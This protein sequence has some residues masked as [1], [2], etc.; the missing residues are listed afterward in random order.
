MKNIHDFVM[1]YYVYFFYIF[2]IKFS[3]GKFLELEPLEAESDSKYVIQSLFYTQR[4]YMMKNKSTKIQF[5]INGL[6]HL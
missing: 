4:K 1:L 5:I 3:D 6:N 2:S